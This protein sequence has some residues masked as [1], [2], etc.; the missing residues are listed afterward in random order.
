MKA[1]GEWVRTDLVFFEVTS[2]Q[3]VLLANLQLVQ[4]RPWKVSHF[5]RRSLHRTQAREVRLGFAMP[6][7]EAVWPCSPAIFGHL[8][9]FGAC[10]E[11]VGANGGYP[12]SKIWQ[13]DYAIGHSVLK[14]F[15]C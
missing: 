12:V 2:R 13:Q 15:V 4:G 9:R 7:G 3:S 8:G 1:Q 14:G 10:Q 5:T 6:W 11:G